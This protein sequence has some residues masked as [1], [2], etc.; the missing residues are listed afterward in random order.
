M[1]HDEDALTY[2]LGYLLA[3]DA[4]FCNKV[5]QLLVRALVKDGHPKGRRPKEF[6]DN[7]AIHLQELSDRTLGRRDIVIKAGSKELIVEAKIGG[8]LPGPKQVIQYS[9]DNAGSPRE[10]VWGVVAITQPEMSKAQLAD[11]HERFIEKAPGKGF[12]AVQWHEIIELAFGHT[13]TNELVASKYLF[14]E[15]LRYVREDYRMGYY[16]AEVSIQDLDPKNATIFEKGWMYVTSQKDKRAPL[17]FAPYY[18]RQ[19]SQSG[20]RFVSRVLRV[21]NVVLDDYSDEE[22]IAM[23]LIASKDEAIDHRSKW[24]LGLSEIRKRHDN[25]HWKDPI[26]RLL[27]LDQPIQIRETPLTKK[28]SKELKLQGQVSKEIPSQ[29]PKGFSLQFDDLLKSVRQLAE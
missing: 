9:L 14:E 2:A 18:A 27:F 20:I 1:G 21:E 29:V 22:I 26:T 12:A 3:Y 4:S 8:G 13:P 23:A 28:A 6:K 15:F 7:Y 19:G 17:Y 11:I 10:E 24:E 5:V 25:E 16:D